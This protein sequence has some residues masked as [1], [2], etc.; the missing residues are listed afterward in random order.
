MN[1]CNA[2][3]KKQSHHDAGRSEEV[4]QFPVV[5]TEN[6]PSFET[7]EDTDGTLTQS[8][9]D[10]DLS[11]VQ[12]DDT[13]EDISDTHDASGHDASGHDT[14]DDI[15]DSESAIRCAQCFDDI[16]DDDNSIEYDHDGGKKILKARGIHYAQV[17]NQHCY[18]ALTD[19]LL[20][21]F[22]PEA[23]AAV[24]DICILRRKQDLEEDC[25]QDIMFLFLFILFQKLNPR[26]M[27]IECP[28]NVRL[29]PTHTRLHFCS[30]DPVIAKRGK[31]IADT[32][33]LKFTCQLVDHADHPAHK[34]GQCTQEFKSLRSLQR[35]YA[36][37]HPD[38]VGN[39]FHWSK[40]QYGQL[41]DLFYNPYPHVCSQCF[42][43]TKCDDPLCCNRTI[44]RQLIQGAESVLLDDNQ[45]VQWHGVELRP[46][47]APGATRCRFAMKPNVHMFTDST[48]L[49]N[50]VERLPGNAK[51]QQ[52]RL[53]NHGKG[54][55]TFK[56]WDQYTIGDKK[57]HFY[58]PPGK[59]WGGNGTLREF[60][61][62]RHAERLALF[63]HE[64]QAMYQIFLNRPYP[65]S[66][67]DFQAYFK[68][69]NYQPL[70][71]FREKGDAC[72]PQHKRKRAGTPQDKR[73][74]AGTPKTIERPQK[75]GKMTTIQTSKV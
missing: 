71:R 42:E 72:T 13:Y 33:K 66:L 12:D 54:I 74:R 45:L 69:Q 5:P 35:H 70:V 41:M 7:D 31:E 38:S 49:K 50:H 36:L 9:T 60:D 40:L 11:D 48:R 21:E 15:S 8:D 61:P 22:T 29:G 14:D 16:T 25:R 62:K 32:A 24:Q 73:K 75:Q 56:R 17:C 19:D 4:V 55:G 20:S 23:L 2:S 47:H 52:G 63:T 64:A 6:E 58:R 26:H 43:T 27:N 18:D 57:D 34:E 44:R 65:I 59:P 53:N 37:H 30:N 46:Y 28:L 1:S 68:E 39:P 67:W 3:G 51:G 10:D